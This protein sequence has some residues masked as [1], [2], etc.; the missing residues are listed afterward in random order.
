MSGR[1]EIRNSEEGDLA[2][3]ETLYPAAFPDENL[4][5]LVRGLLLDMAVTTSLVGV[6][7]SQVTGHV[8]FT[9]C[10]VSGS[11]IHAALLAPLA[12]APARQR[13]GIGSALVHSGLRRLAC[14]D[15]NM[16]FVLGDPAY[17]KRLGFVPESAVEP[18]YRLP[19]Q[20][21]GAWQSQLLG[22]IIA[23]CAGKLSVPRQW[24]NPA[25][26]AP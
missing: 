16:V 4:L 3:I 25:L 7:N 8:I 24:L 12:V 1:L 23:P 17:Y 11:N 14:L 13:Q 19:A 9:K 5:P 18:P 22:N 10:S 21:T 15:I 2:A 6:I 26:W 20:W